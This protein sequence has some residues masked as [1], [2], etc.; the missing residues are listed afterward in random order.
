MAPRRPHLHAPWGAWPL[1]LINIF[2]LLPFQLTRSVGSVTFTFTLVFAVF[3]I[4]THTLRGERD[5]KFFGWFVVQIISTH[6]LRGERDFCK[7]FTTHHIANFNSHAP[8]GAWRGT[9]L[10]PIDEKIISTHTL[11]GERDTTHRIAKKQFKISTHTLRGERDLFCLHFLPFCTISTHT[12]RGERD[13]KINNDKNNGGNFNSHAPWGA[14][15]CIQT[16]NKKRSKFQ[17]TRSVGSVTKFY[18]LYSLDIFISTH[19]LR[20]ERDWRKDVWQDLQLQFQLTR[21]VGSVTWYFKSFP[22]FT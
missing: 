6:T 12:L 2:V 8:W 5:F 21:S 13:K 20:G 1:P 17:L 11:R 22:I 15:H 16:I 4:S 19:T 14:W 3:C 9:I 10:L 18:R 7:R